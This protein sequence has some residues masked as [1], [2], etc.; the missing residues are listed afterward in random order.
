M[1]WI[2]ALLVAC[3]STPP[4]LTEVT[5]VTPWPGETLTVRGTDL[6][7]DV[8]LELVRGPQRVPLPVSWAD[9]GALQADLPPDTPPGAWYVVARNAGGTTPTPPVIEVWTPD[10]EPACTKRYALHTETHRTQRKIAF[11]RVFAN[12][13]VEHRV[14]LGDELARLLVERTALP[15][16]VTCT[17]LWLEDKDNHRWLIADDTHERIVERARSIAAALDLPLSGA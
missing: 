5:P 16:G 9:D 11:D 10:S 14:F 3:S 1:I 7:P 17:A 13:P 15:D 6:T 2:V 12:H 4:G 8:E